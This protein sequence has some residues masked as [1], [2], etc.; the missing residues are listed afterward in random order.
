[1]TWRV[2][3]CAHLHRKKGNNLFGIKA[4]KS[5]QGATN[6]TQTQEFVQGRMQTKQEPFRAYNS[7]QES[8]AD[9]ASFL[10]DNPRYDQALKAV[11]SQQF[12]QQLQ[13]AGYATDPGYASK[14]EKVFHTLEKIIP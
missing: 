9:F 14:L 1:M 6:I 11:N 3:S 5:W 2:S 13:Q 8:V 12:F 7:L 10:I 4:D